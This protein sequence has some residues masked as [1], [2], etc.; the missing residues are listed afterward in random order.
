MCNERKGFVMMSFAKRCKPNKGLDYPAPG[1]ST[2]DPSY[3]TSSSKIGEYHYLHSDENF[4]TSSLINSACSQ[5]RPQ[6]FE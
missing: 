6:K 4:K 2:N 3:A 1:P 5:Q